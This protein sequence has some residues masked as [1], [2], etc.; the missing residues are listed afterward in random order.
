MAT[1]FPRY[2]RITT[3]PKILAGKP[4]IR[5]L[6]ISVQ[7][8]LQIL[9]ENPLWEDLRADYPELEPDDIQQ[10]LAFAAEQ[11]TDRFLPLMPDAA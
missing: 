5:G 1:P 3:D 8:V 6:R 7:Q 4:C 2:P 10:A 11:L 9:S